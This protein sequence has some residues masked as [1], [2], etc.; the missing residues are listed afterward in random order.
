LD[1]YIVVAGTRPEIIK[2]APIIREILHLKKKLYFIHT[3][4]HYDFYLSRQMILDLDLP[5]PNLS[6]QLKSHSPASQIAEIMR[7]LES[8][9]TK[10]FRKNLV[11]VQ[12]DTNSVLSASLAAVKSGSPLAHVEAGLR[13][14]DWR[15]PEEHNRRMVDHISNYLFA[16]TKLSMSNLLMEK[17]FGHVYMTGNT[18]IDAVNQHIPIAEKKSTDKGTIPLSRFVLATF[19]R[20]E[21]VDDRKVLTNI[22]NGLLLTEIPIIISMHP[23]TKKMLRRFDLFQKLSKGKHIRITGP[24]GYLDFLLLMKA[25][26]LIVTDSGGIQ[27]EATAPTIAKRVIV[28][29][30]STERQEAVE[31]RFAKLVNLKEKDIAREIRKQWF[32]NKTPTSKSPYGDGFS[33]RRIIKILNGVG[34]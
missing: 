6:F 23:R 10:R 5:E 20:S 22:V 16:P 25:S 13:S 15:M 24:R 27:E 14:F 3:G 7:K 34:R 2:V 30:R 9:L 8:V 17:V 32:T 18:V 1:A 4:Q 31:A 12:G 26:K 28:L 29:R 11:I 21:N 19:H 33:S